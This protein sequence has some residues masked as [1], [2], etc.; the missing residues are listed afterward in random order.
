MADHLWYSTQNNHN[1]RELTIVNVAQLVGKAP[2][3]E[4][5]IRIKVRMLLS[6]DMNMGAPEWLQKSYLFVAETGDCVTPT[7]E[8]KGYD[9]HFSAENLFEQEG[10]KAPKCQM[11]SF[12]I[13]ECGDSE[14]PDVAVTFTLYCQFS[15]DLW[16]WLGA[17]GGETCWC[18]FTPGV[19]VESPDPT[20]SGEELLLTSGEDEEEPE[21]NDDE[22]PDEDDL[23]PDNELEG[24]E[25]DSMKTMMEDALHVFQQEG[26]V[27]ASSIQRIL[28]I[29]YGNAVHIID[30]LEAKG[31]VSSTDEHGIRS[32]TALGISMGVEQ[33]VKRGR[34][35][36]RKNPIDPVPSDASMAF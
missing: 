31:L 12:E 34:G 8:F 4:K 14:E 28:S 21:F 6:A 1:Q 29:N 25:S 7:V 3:K 35:R 16:S 20:N 15:M 2:T 33:P 17:F 13:H 9:L 36:P 27:S 22:E 10:V 32:L 23:D 26:K 24:I 11:R 5:R 18:K 19:V 30:A